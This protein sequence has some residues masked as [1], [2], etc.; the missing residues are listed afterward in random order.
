LS[1][2]VGEFV[3]GP[4]STRSTTS[5]EAAT[6]ALATSTAIS[7]RDRARPAADRRSMRPQSM[8]TM[9]TQQQRLGHRD[10]PGGPEAEP[11]RKH[12][13]H[14]Y[15]HCWR[16]HQRPPRPGHRGPGP[17]RTSPGPAPAA[18]ST[19]ATRRS[20]AP[21]A[22]FSPSRPR[23]PGGPRCPPGDRCLS[24]R[25]DQ[26]GWEAFAARIGDLLMVAMRSRC[27]GGLPYPDFP[28]V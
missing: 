19:Q 8:A 5:R 15:G 22:A 21:P 2:S 25:R 28:G 26:K 27:H 23:R 3:S 20:P 9:A 11:G 4:P 13:R 1:R 16:A 14:G 10:G 17:G 18:D 12:Q 6:A 24:S 7:A